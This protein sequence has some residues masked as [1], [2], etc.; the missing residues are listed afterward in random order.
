[1]FAIAI[2]VMA[3]APVLDGTWSSPTCES[4][5][6]G[7][8]HFTRTFKLEKDRWAID[9]STYGDAACKEKMVT[10][11]IDGPLKLEKPSAKVKGATEAQFLFAHRKATPRSEGAAK[12]LS[13]VKA[14]GKADWKAGE[15]VDIDASG[16]PQLGAYP[17]AQCAGEFDLVK[18]EGDQLYFGARP[19][20]GNLCSKEKRPQA[21]GNPVKKS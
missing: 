3:A 19:A 14:C 9:F 21:L 11:D 6:D 15:S 17:K 10:V 12:W 16:C 5:P 18:V 7:S 20:D 2:A 4:T 1:M 13:S 8:M